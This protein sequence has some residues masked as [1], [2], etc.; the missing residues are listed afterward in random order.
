MRFSVLCQEISNE[1]DSYENDSY[2][3]RELREHLAL[4][5]CTAVLTEVRIRAACDSAGKTAL[6][7]VLK[8]DN[9]NE[10]DC[11]REQ[12]CTENV[13]KRTHL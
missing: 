9:N 3:R 8:N 12:N 10:E 13:L 2:D 4:C 1:N 5:R 7:F 6:S 11:R